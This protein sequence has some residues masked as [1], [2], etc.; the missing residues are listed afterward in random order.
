[1]RSTRISDW[2]YKGYIS[3]APGSK[4]GSLKITRES[5]ALT[6]NPWTPKPQALNPKTLSPKP[7]LGMRARWGVAERDPCEEVAGTVVRQFRSQWLRLLCPEAMI[8]RAC[9]S[10]RVDNGFE[11]ASCSDRALDRQ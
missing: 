4:L 7:Q 11:D 6:L 2:F 9:E 10:A 1:M 8:N 5:E 3:W